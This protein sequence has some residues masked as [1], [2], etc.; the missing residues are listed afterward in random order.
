MTLKKCDR[1]GKQYSPEDYEAGSVTLYVYDS[2]HTSWPDGDLFDYCP[3][4][5]II[6]DK[7]LRG[8]K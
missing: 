1:C 8:K 3:E 5:S 2:N 6:V 7:F 4:C